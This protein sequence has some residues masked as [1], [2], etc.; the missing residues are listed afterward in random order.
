MSNYIKLRTRL[1]G[2]HIWKWRI[3]PTEKLLRVYIIIMYVYF[4]Y[5]HHYN[6]LCFVKFKE[7][8]ATVYSVSVSD[9][10]L[11]FD[12]GVLADTSTPESIEM[13]DDDLVDVQVKYRCKIMCVVMESTLLF[14]TRIFNLYFFLN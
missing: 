2:K 5:K 3:N 7:N 13:E 8:F 6:L 4:V 1:N 9:L 14:K 12:G 11:K 10:T